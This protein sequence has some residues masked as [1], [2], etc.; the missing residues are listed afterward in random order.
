MVYGEATGSPSKLSD[1]KFRVCRFWTSPVQDVA[2]GS[3]VPQLKTLCRVVSKP[4]LRLLRSLDK[5]SPGEHPPGALYADA[6]PKK[7]AAKLIRS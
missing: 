4:W 3:S 5:E 2:G 6:T 7:Y 1:E